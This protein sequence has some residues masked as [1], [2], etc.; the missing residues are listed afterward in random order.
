VF[1][2]QLDRLSDCIPHTELP[3]TSKLFADLLYNYAR[4]AK[5]YGHDPF[6]ASSFDAAAKQIQYPDERRAAMAKALAG[7]NAPSE[8]LTRFAQPGTVAVVTG[9]QVGLFGGPA[10]TIYKALTAA[11]L[12]KNLTA[13]GISAVPIFWM[14]TEDHDFAEVAHTWVFDGDGH[15]ARL[16]VESAVTGQKPAGN[17]TIA[18]P[19][20]EELRAA[21][22]GFPHTEEVIAAVKDAYQPGATMGAGFRALVLK[23][24]ERVGVLVLDPLDPAIRAIGAPLMASAVKAAPE[25]KAALLARG[26][27]LTAA[28]YH[29]QVMVEEKTSLFFLL[30]KG[31]RKTLRLKDSECAQLADRAADVSPNALLR[32]VW[33]DYMLPTIAYVGG[34]GELAYFAQSAVLYDKLLGRMPVVLPRACFTL[35]D[36]RSE[37]LMKKFGFGLADMMVKQ[38][39]LGARIAKQLVPETLGAEFDQTESEATRSL[40]KMAASLQTFDPTLAAAMAKSRAKVLYQIEKLRRKTE[41]ETLRRDARATADAAYLRGLLYPEDHL[42]ERLHA[43][44]PFLAKY[45]MD[46]VDR[47]YEQVKPECPDHRILSL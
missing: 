20:I 3:G 25:L 39:V 36:A 15:T 43:I 7:Q 14:A 21:M 18:Q 45:G 11:K 35:L 12:A 9:Q 37:K 27:E 8:L 40:D 4:V 44:L 26:A 24:L 16:H 46:L 13:R 33:Q 28:G 32:P 34:P 47:L 6:Q 41:R 31:E 19:P 22:S 23:L 2:L 5:F 10:Y 38:D 17:Y 42:Q 29:S 30:E 1:L